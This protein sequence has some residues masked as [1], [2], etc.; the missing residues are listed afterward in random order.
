MSSMK[1]F[2]GDKLTV[3]RNMKFVFHSVENMLE[4][5]GNASYQHF[6]HFQQCFQIAL[7]SGLID[8]VTKLIFCLIKK[9]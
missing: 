4:T 7:S 2:A 1:A 3:T 6:L 8:C 9:E 5:R